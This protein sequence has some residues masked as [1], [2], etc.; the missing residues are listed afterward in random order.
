MYACHNNILMNIIKMAH[1]A[2]YAFNTH[3]EEYLTGLFLYSCNWI[4]IEE[5]SK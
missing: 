1:I 2:V 4:Y 5:V 3:V